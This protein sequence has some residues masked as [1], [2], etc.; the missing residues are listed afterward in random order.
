[1]TLFRYRALT[2]SGTRQRGRMEATDLRDLEQ[3]L[4]ASG[5]QLINGEPCRMML[6]RRRLPRREL[7][8]TSA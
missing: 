1:M 2:L 5:L 4:H 6:P 7:I 3:R 8:Q